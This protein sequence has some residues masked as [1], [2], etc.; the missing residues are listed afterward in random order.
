MPIRKG[1]NNPVFKDLLS[2]FDKGEIIK[3]LG[4]LTPLILSVVIAY[5]TH[6]DVADQIDLASN[7][8]KYGKDKDSLDNV[9]Q[10]RKDKISF[11]KDSLSLE[12]A[13]RSLDS[14][15][16]DTKEIL[17]ASEKNNQSYLREISRLLAIQAKQAE[18]LISN[19][20]LQK[21]LNS[22]V[23]E[24]ESFQ[25]DSSQMRQD[26][27]STDITLKGK[28]KLSN[29][30]NINIK[31]CLGSLYASYECSTN[32]AEKYYS[33]TLGG[34]SQI[35]GMF[36]NKNQEYIDIMLKTLKIANQIE[37][38]FEISAHNIPT[39]FVYKVDILFAF[40][41]SSDVF[42]DANK[43]LYKPY[44][45]FLMPINGSYH[46]TIYNIPLTKE[47]LGI[48][49]KYDPNKI[50]S[51]DEIFQNQSYTRDSNSPFL[52]KIFN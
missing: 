25:L 32:Q 44:S 52:P 13:R 20:D 26:G 42:N 18:A 21:D 4:Y 27:N 1:R 11:T 22:P 3:F 45:V 33:F 51:I 46:R 5:Y 28:F 36:T 19:Y 9:D 48:M 6:L 12:Y 39:A 47:T 50:K 38:G 43:S 31:D 35:S 7:Q 23:L 24:I 8:F 2:N 49:F 16:L 29:I 40:S 15:S 10:Q 37:V 41:Y 17:R 14:I 34:P 30:G